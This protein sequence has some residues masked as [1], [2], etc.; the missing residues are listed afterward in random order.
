MSAT[1]HLSKDQFPLYHG[2]SHAFE[3]GDT[4]TPGGGPSNYPE[5]WGTSQYAW[6]T[7]HPSEAMLHSG[8][9]SV[10]SVEPLRDDL[11]PD[12]REPHAY[13][14]ESGFRVTEVLG[15]EAL[16]QHIA[17]YRRGRA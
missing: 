3:V 14:S 9:G 16:K 8:S 1:E 17:R 5:H 11:V 6:A 7:K 2:S 10:Y 15:R 13:A 12:P 4:V